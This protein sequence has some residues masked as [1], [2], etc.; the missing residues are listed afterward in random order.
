MLDNNEV[1]VL[2]AIMVI[3]NSFFHRLFDIT[4]YVYNSIGMLPSF[5]ELTY[6]AFEFPTDVEINDLY[7]NVKLIAKQY[8]GK[9]AIRIFPYVSPELYANNKKNYLTELDLE[10]T[11]SISSNNIDEVANN[12]YRKLHDSY[13]PN[14]I[15]AKIQNAIG[16]TIVEL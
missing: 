4:N 2:P 9:A 14:L 12:L 1:C 16:L 11:I 15:H 3:K 13:I 5:S 8:Y 7:E 6:H 10:N